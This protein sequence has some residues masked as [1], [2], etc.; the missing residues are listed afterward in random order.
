[1]SFFNFNVN[2]V[3]DNVKE[4]V[5]SI[6]V[7]KIENEEANNNESELDYSYITPNL[8][9]LGNITNEY[10]DDFCG[11]FAT[12]N[13]MLWNISGQNINNKFKINF[14]NQILDFP[15]NQVCPFS[16][17]PSFDNIFALC[18]SIKSYLD[19]ND[20][21]L[22]II[23]CKNGRSRTGIIIACFLKYINS[24]EN[25]AAAFNF[26]CSKRIQSSNKP[27]L[28]P[29]YGLLFDNIDKVVNNNQYT[30]NEPMHLKFISLSGLP[31]DEIP[32]L[33]L[34]DKNGIY[35][36][37][38]LSKISIYLKSLFIYTYGFVQS[39]HRCCI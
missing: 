2:E 13:V 18:Y 37:I 39:N 27:N 30:N 9:A 12:N 26:F 28:S 19:L 17:A 7:N 25:S 32:C 16:K 11:L 31:L 23:H 5:K 33:E 38:H 36:S 14:N 29:T 24:F 10:I 15:W 20:K 21:N 1:M 4:G 8:I 34:W 35:L 6:S 22:V 3:W